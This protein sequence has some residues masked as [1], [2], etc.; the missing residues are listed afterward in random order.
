MMKIYDKID[1]I[2]SNLLRAFCMSCFLLLCTTIMI[3]IIIVITTIGFI[4]ANIG[5]TLGVLITIFFIIV[6]VLMFFTLIL[7]LADKR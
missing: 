2:E 6:N 1:K 7:Y 5:G 4:L 3:A